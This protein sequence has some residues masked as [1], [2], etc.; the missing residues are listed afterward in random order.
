ME[1]LDSQET[2][3]VVYV[4]FGSITVMTSEQLTEFAWGLMNSKKTFL[5][6]IRADLVA[7]ATAV[8]PPE[9]VEETRSRGFLA[10]WCPQEKV[11]SHRAI[12]GFLTHCGWN[13]T[14]ESICAGVPLICWPFFAEQQTNCR[15]SCEEWGI[16]M[17]IEGDV[18][19]EEIERLERELMQGEKG[20]EMKRKA[21]EWRKF[22]EEAT[23]SPSG[24]SF[25]NFNKM[26]SPELFAFRK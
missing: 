1:W 20:R 8:L 24:S 17:E 16:G 6:I 22:A 18:K 23:M 14:V 21:L 11:L 12:G 9:F 26:V 13:S 2:D 3:T 7:G 4:N 15:Y 19:R 5:W 25:L 10:S